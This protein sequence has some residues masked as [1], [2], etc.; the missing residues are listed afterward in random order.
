[1]MDEVFDFEL[2]HQIDLTTFRFIYTRRTISLRIQNVPK[3]LR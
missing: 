3:L 2:M 1:M